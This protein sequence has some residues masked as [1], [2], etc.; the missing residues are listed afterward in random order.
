MENQNCKIAVG[1][2][3][4]G[5]FFATKKHQLKTRRIFANIVSSK[6]AVGWFGL[7]GR[8]I[9]YQIFGKTAK[10]SPLPVNRLNHSPGVDDEECAYLVVITMEISES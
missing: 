2:F 4:H 1:R 9:K 8:G 5:K 7:G 6:I 10:T 3:G